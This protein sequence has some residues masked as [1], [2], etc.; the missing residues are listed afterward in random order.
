MS[1]VLLYQCLDYSEPSQASGSRM[2]ENVRADA[3]CPLLVQR[4]T[5]R[6]KNLN[7]VAA[8]I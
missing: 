1:W 3:S 6:D 7:I 5:R 8:A 4:N 2:F